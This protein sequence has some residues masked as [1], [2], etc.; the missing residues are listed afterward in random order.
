MALGLA[1]VWASLLEGAKKNWRARFLLA[2]FAASCLLWTAGSPAGSFPPAPTLGGVAWLALPC[3]VL[4]ALSF[5]AAA[6]RPGRGA[7]FGILAG[8]LGFCA[9]RWPGFAEAFLRLGHP[10]SPLAVHFCVPLLLAL[11]LAFLA[12]AFGHP[13]Y[14]AAVALIWILITGIVEWRLRAA[15]G[16]GPRDLSQ[17]AGL[18]IE[19]PPTTAVAVSGKL[20]I[21]PNAYGTENLER[22]ERYLA[23]RQFRAVFAKEAADALRFGRLSRWDAEQA[24]FAETMGAPA[25]TPDYR[26]ALALLRAGPLTEA[27][28]E[29]L[30]HLAGLAGES[31]KGFESITQSQYIFEAFS[32][33]FGR[34]GEAESARFWL[35][36]IDR[37][38]PIYEKKVEASPVESM[39]DGQISGSLLMDGRPTPD[40]K[41]GL[42][43]V[44][45]GTD[46]YRDGAN[47]CCSQYPDAGGEFV[48]SNLGEGKYRL[49]LQAPPAVL[50]G[51]VRNDPGVITLREKGRTVRV[52]PILIERR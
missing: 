48:F 21:R 2:A 15:Y 22:L 23:A 27:R 28:F 50:R 18:A 46:T 52:D 39:I 43:Y 17:A 29:S 4:G 16:Y 7:A 30:K 44:S 1:A 34:F 47:L 8:V 45:P 37:L 33:A 35:S 42:F 31:P 11:S 24:L 14:H 32:A 26:Q 41:V 20:E 51:A 49:A 6:A 40:V 10:F 13:R 25:L 19:V 5:A 9:S 12:L 36:K 3:V 38:W